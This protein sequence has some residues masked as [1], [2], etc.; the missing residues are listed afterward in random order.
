MTLVLFLGVLFV[1]ILA[2]LPVAFA[3]LLAS[4]PVDADRMRELALARAGA[5]RDAL[6]RLG[7]DHERLYLLAPT[8]PEQGTTDGT[9]WQAGVMLGLKTE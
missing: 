2:G 5:V 9:P 8:G 1:A 4:I 6:V 7:V 3:L